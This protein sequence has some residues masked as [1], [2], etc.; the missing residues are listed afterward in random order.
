MRFICLLTLSILVSAG[1]QGHSIFDRQV[2]REDDRSKVN[3]SVDVN[4]KQTSNTRH[5]LCVIV[6]CFS[7]VVLSCMFDEVY[8]YW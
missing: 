7:L 5:L 3:Q 8:K 6:I 1:V 4:G 2:N